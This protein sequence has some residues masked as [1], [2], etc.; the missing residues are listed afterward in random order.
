MGLPRG[1]KHTEITKRKISEKL[2]E[3]IFSK[4]H[5]ENLSQSKTGSKHHNWKGGR[6]KVKNGRIKLWIPGHLYADASGYVFEHRLIMEKH[7]G[8]IL[9]PNEVVHH[10][11]GIVWDN[12]IENLAL[13]DDTAKHTSLHRKKQTEEQHKNKKRNNK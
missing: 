13:F 10:I 5:K 1:F 2:N 9:L 6:I 11:N 12:Q 4:K 8:R 3:R 7:L